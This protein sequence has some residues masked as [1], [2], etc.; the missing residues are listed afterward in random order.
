MGDNGDAK[1]AVEGGAANEPGS[2][3]VPFGRAEKR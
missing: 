3:A 2:G 1:A